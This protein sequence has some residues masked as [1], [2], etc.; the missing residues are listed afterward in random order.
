MFNRFYYNNPSVQYIHSEHP[1]NSMADEER[2]HHCHTGKLT[3][4]ID[5]M[6]RKVKTPKL[7]CPVCNPV[8]P[9]PGKLLGC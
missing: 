2:T 7:A 5:L 1:D 8:S 4:V 3:A 9:R 6:L